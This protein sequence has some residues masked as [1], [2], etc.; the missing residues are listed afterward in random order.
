M[1][2]KNICFLGICFS[3]RCYRIVN[4]NFWLSCMCLGDTIAKMNWLKFRFRLLLILLH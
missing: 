4:Q 2:F 1:Y 3:M